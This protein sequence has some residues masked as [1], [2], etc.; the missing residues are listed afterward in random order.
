M[1]SR[2]IEKMTRL[3]DSNLLVMNGNRLLIE[4]LS[5]GEKT[6]KSGIIAEIEKKAKV[7]GSEGDRARVAVVL[8]VGPGY[9]TDEGEKVPVE[10][11]QGDMVLVNQFG[12]K[13]FGDFFGLADYK[14]D[15]IGLATEDLIQGR[16]GNFDDFN[17]ILKG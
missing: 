17:G 1:K 14:P 6:T 9:E 12:I 13:T 15:S 7:G 3:T 11:K 4:L 8:A 16:I 5:E 10:Y 2:Y